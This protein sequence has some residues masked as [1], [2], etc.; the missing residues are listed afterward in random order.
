MDA[1]GITQAICNSM[2]D[3]EVDP[4]GIPQATRNSMLGCEVD[5]RGNHTNKTKHCPTQNG[6][7]DCTTQSGENNFT[8]A[9]FVLHK[10]ESS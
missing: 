2:L 9:F 8:F 3:C 7:N 5:S 10:I 4:D 1:D 6:K